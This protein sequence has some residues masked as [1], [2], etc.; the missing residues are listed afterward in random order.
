MD[1]KD[2]M[3]SDISQRK[4]HTIWFHLYVESKRQNKWTKKKKTEK[5]HRYREQTDGWQMGG[6]ERTGLKKV[7]GLSGTNWQL[8][9]NHEDVRYSL[10]NID[11]NIVITIRGICVYKTYLGITS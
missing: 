3:T 1:P 2:I 6:G 8:Q 9:T 4:T 5:T 11:N 10:G 7:K